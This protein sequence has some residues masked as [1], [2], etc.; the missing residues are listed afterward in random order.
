VGGGRDDDFARQR[1]Q[2]AFDGHHQHDGGIA[3]RLQR[4]IIPIAQALDDLMHG[5][6]FI[7]ERRALWTGQKLVPDF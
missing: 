2:G 3:A 5:A 7:A 6:Q 1:E 4:M